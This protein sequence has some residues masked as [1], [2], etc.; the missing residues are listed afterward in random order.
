MCCYICIK[1]KNKKRQ[2]TRLYNALK[3]EESNWIYSLVFSSLD[4]NKLDSSFNAF[5]VVHNMT[6]KCSGISH[7][8]CVRILFSSEIWIKNLLF[9]TLI[10]III[11]VEHYYCIYII[12]IMLFYN[13]PCTITGH[14]TI[15]YCSACI[16]SDVRRLL[17][18]NTFIMV[19]MSFF[20][21][22]LLIWFLRKLILKWHIFIFMSTFCFVRFFYSK[23]Q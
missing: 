8:S 21:I 9:F 19:T 20:E 17:T 12:I 23:A 6:I 16:Y 4:R 18:W 11:I 1:K 15:L 3:V 5:I 14:R 22:G 7:H 2:Y 13:Y 10:N